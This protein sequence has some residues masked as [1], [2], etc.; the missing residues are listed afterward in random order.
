MPRAHTPS[1]ASGRRPSELRRWLAA[2]WEDSVRRRAV[3]VGL[4]VGT[5]LALI[6]HGDRLFSA[7]MDRGA[8]L[9]ICLTYVVPYC[10]STWASVQAIRERERTSASGEC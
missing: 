6:N 2:A 8:W 5:V 4:V 1:L 3:R 10:V 7:S 9:R